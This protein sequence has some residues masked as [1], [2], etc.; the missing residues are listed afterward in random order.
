M[1]VAFSAPY[2][3]ERLARHSSSVRRD[4]IRLPSSLT[5]PTSIGTFF[6]ISGALSKKERMLIIF[7]STQG[8]HPTRGVPCAPGPI[9]G[10]PVGLIFSA[11]ALPAANSLAHSV[12][13]RA[14]MSFAASPSS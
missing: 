6:E 14:P 12:F 10:G 5:E 9:L 7:P 3:L 13:C 8:D 11:A 1:A 2:I 4:D